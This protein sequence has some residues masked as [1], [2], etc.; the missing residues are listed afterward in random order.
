MAFLASA[1]QATVRGDDGRHLL[2][3]GR[4]GERAGAGELGAGE[5]VMNEAAEQHETAGDDGRDGYDGCD[6]DEG[7]VEDGGEVEEDAE[8]D[9]G[10]HEEGGDGV[11]EEP[12]LLGGAVGGVA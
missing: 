9:D 11:E 5:E 12:D 10:E 3:V 2:A 7:D 1:V 6:D 4:G 8:G